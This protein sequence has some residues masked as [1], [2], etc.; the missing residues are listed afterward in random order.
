MWIIFEDKT[1]VQTNMICLYSTI[2]NIEIN[3]NND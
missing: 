2:L 3:T 1:I